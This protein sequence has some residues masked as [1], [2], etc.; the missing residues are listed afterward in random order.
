MVMVIM[1][2]VYTLG[3]QFTTEQDSLVVGNRLLVL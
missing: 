3:T 1:S 2:G